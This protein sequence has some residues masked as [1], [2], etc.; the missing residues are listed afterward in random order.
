MR[1]PE[2]DDSPILAPM[3]A[4]CLIGP[5]TA[6]KDENSAKAGHFILETREKPDQVLREIELF[7]DLAAAKLYL[8]QGL[9]GD[10]VQ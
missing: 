2:V 3:A 7:T 1:S 5:L 6:I 9:S 8:N 4:F 10:S